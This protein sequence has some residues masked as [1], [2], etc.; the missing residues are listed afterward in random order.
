MH[1]QALTHSPH[2]KR[3]QTHKEWELQEKCEPVQKKMHAA[4]LVLAAQPTVVRALSQPLAQRRK[5][6]A[7]PFNFAEQAQRE[8]ANNGNKMHEHELGMHQSASRAV[9]TYGIRTSECGCPR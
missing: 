1:Q 4:M 7:F 5:V 8:P 2:K 6:W 9:G 3:N